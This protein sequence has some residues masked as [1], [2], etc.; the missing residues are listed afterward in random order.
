MLNIKR[1][2]FTHTNQIKDVRRLRINFALTHFPASYK[3][4]IL[5][6]EPREWHT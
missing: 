3:L 5:Q 6:G 1:E 4:H 2:T